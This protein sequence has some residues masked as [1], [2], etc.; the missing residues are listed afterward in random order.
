MF[1][2]YN[3]AA[4]PLSY[5]APQKVQLSLPLQEVTYF[6]CTYLSVGGSVHTPEI[7]A[8]LVC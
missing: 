8:A 6:I 1:V 3:K 4:P 2:Q 7:D 5:A